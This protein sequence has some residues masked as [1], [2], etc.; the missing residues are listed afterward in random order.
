MKKGKDDLVSA[1]EQEVAANPNNVVA[2]HRLAL[3]YWRA[4]RLEDAVKAFQKAI[5]LDPNSF[6]LRVISPTRRN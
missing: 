5:V 3:A 6:E 1:L 2:V 4:D